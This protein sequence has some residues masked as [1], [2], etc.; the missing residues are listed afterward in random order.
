MHTIAIPVPILVIARILGVDEHRVEEFRAWSEASILGLNP[1]RTPEET[2]RMEWGSGKLQA[3]FTELMTARRAAPKDDL[4]SDMVGLQ[5]AGA[6]IADEEVRVNLS[7]LLIGG[8]L[9]TTD[10]IGNGVWLLL[11]HPEELAKL[12]ADPSL[13]ASA[14]EEILRYESPV[15]ITSRVASSEREVGG[16]P[17][18]PRHALMVSLHAANRDPE[19][20]ET[21]DRFDITRKHA[22]HVAFGGGSHICIGAPL[23]RIEAKKALV[24]L[25]QRYPDLK[26]PEQE[27]VWRALP[28]FRGIET[29]MVAP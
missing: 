16:C 15:A 18:H 11:R 26:L 29:L 4:I 21:P 1:V 12:K 27:I 23:A 24:K 7:A 2:E 6:P 25:F 9:T 8:N 20:F 13:A 28:F 5:A 17:V 14:V 19:I 3:Y 10:L 22:P